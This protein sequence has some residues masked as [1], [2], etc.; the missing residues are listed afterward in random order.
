LVGDAD[1][2]PADHGHGITQ[3]VPVP[4]RETGAGG[5]GRCRGPTTIPIPGP[6]GVIVTGMPSGAQS[7]IQ[8]ATSIGRLMQPWLIGTPKLACQ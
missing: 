2:G 1:C 6:Y 4:L 8:A 7:Y 3:G 5:P